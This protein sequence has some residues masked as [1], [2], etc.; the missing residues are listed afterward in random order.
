MYFSILSHIR[1]ILA[2]LPQ[3]EE[4]EGNN[5]SQ[6]QFIFSLFDYLTSKEKLYS[7]SNFLKVIYIF[8]Y[9]TLVVE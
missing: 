4:F 3:I 7:D 6:T 1:E 8:H 5:L 2:K 9:Y